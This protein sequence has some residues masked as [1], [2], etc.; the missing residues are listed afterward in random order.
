MNQLI[1][2]N[3]K[4][5]SMEKLA[6]ITSSSRF[7]IPPRIR[8]NMFVM[9]ETNILFIEIIGTKHL[10]QF[11]QEAECIIVLRWVQIW[12]PYR[13]NIVITGSRSCYWCKGLFSVLVCCFHW[14]P[15]LDNSSSTA[16]D[17]LSKSPFCRYNKNGQRADSQIP[18]SLM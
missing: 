1:L 9:P 5:F 8:K 3:T 16:R 14:R 2:K 12:Q 6:K 4:E 15:H 18:G 17:T 10:V 13:H 7:A 11:Q